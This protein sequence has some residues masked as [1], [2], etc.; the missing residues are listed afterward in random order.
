MFGLDNMDLSRI[1]FAYTVSVHFIFVPLTIGLSLLMAIME[2]IYVKT[3][4]EIYKQMVQF[5]AILFAMNFAMGVATGVPMEFQFGTNWSYYAHYVGDVFGSPLAIEGLMAFFLEATF[6]GLFFFGWNKLS[7]VQHATVTWLV[8]LGSNFSAIWILIANGWM[9]NP[10]GA[11]FNLDTMRME[12]DDFWA[13]VLNPAAQ[14]RFLHTLTASYILGSVFVIGVS[15]LYLLRGKNIEFAKRSIMV[16]AVVGIISTIATAIAGDMQGKLVHKTQHAKMAAVEAIW[17]T[18]E[19]PAGVTLFALPSQSGEKN[20]FEVR[21]P[22]ALGML[23]GDEVKGIKDVRKDYESRIRSGLIA[24]DALN[25]YKADKTNEQARATFEAHVADL[26]YALLLFRNLTDI[27]QATD[28]DIQMAAAS[29]MPKVAPLFFSFRLMVGL[30]VFFLVFFTTVYVMTIRNTY[31]KSKFMQ[32]VALWI[33]PLPWFAIFAGWFVAEY[34]RQPW[35]IQD[36]LPTFRAASHLSSAT[37]FSS[38]L[39]FFIIYTCLVIVDAI[40]MVKQVKKGPENT[41]NSAN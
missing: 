26:G 32:Y 28:Q 1:Q 2:T 10:I 40:L 36:I 25:K 11:Y 27:T 18:E 21:I 23:V 34:G 35:V 4:K 17:E 12:M 37:V 13:V 24:Y 31:V 19:F 22:K 33:I 29:S 41:N 16:A 39:G 30:G 9:Q 15:S 14:Y 6:I 20:F 7:K 8:F 3:G 38:L 5:W